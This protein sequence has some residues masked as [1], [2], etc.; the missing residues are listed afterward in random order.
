M[1]QRS[2]AVTTVDPLPT[3]QINGV[4]HAQAM[5]GNVVYA[6]GTFSKARPA[7][8]AAGVNEV[9]RS[10]L[11]SYSITSGVLTSFAPTFNGQ[12]KA[13]AT[14][15]DGAT[16]YVGGTFTTVNGTAR[17]R[18]AAFDV[19]TG[20]LKTLQADLNSTVNAIA[21]TPSTVYLG[22]AFS[23]VGSATRSRLAAITTAGALT[24]W[25][26][27]ANAGVQAL[28][29][30]PDQT[31][32]VAGGSFSTLN[33]TTALGMGAVDAASGAIRTWRINTVVKNYGDG[34]AV[35]SLVADADTIYGTAYGYLGTANYE[36]VFAASPSDGA[37]R[38]LQ[39]CHGDTY[40][41][42]PV[43]GTVYSV[44]H[45]HFC[46]N[47]GGFGETRPEHYR[48]LAVTK[49]VGGTVA[50]NTQLGSGYGDFEGQPAPAMINWFPNL[51]PGSFT[52]QT[53]AAWSITGNSSYISL[54]GEFPTV[55]GVKQQGLVRMA[56]P[57]L[58]PRKQG[59][60]VRTAEAAP[61][62]TK[63][64]NGRSVSWKTN[65]DR[66]DQNL[67]Y[68]VL[69]GGVVVHT[70]TVV[71]RFWSRPVVTWTDTTAAPHLTYSYQIRVRDPDANS[72]T[73]ASV[74]SS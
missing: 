54:G 27:Q 73:S 48:A 29:L 37:V 68:D 25:A 14:S 59:P 8:S 20:A 62:V 33:G 39:D 36:G 1:Q 19:A 63:V 71:S 12:V 60:V 34:G 40:D 13:L 9:T 17:N 43:G 44:G 53:Q 15:P 72:Y 4:V 56:V 45:A 65:W 23:R 28:V 38:W 2:S 58:A 49:A 30:T 6:G 46:S 24:G 35:L 47:I 42:L 21:A 3:V 32:V 66:D 51:Q 52:G 16:L 57:S 5:A 70:R 74:T 64:S 18:F 61:T 55:N 50:K 7:G 10:N 31:K 69:R 26:P 67:S 41:A 11:L 22:G